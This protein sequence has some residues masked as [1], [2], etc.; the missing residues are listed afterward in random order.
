M[1]SHRTTTMLKDTLPMEGRVSEPGF[2]HNGSK[3]LTK[4]HQL[5]KWTMKLTAYTIPSETTATTNIMDHF[6]EPEL[7]SMQLEENAENHHYDI[8]NSIS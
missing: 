1:S 5:A 2:Q 8:K 3:K 4:Q 6:N 7:A